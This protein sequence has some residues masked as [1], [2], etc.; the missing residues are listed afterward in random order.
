MRNDDVLELARLIIAA[1]QL[2]IS[3][4]QLSKVETNRSQQFGLKIEPPVPVEIDYRSLRV[5]NGKVEIHPDVYHRGTNNIDKLKEMLAA[6]GIC[7]QD[8]SMEEQL[9]LVRALRDSHSKPQ[10]VEL[11]NGKE[12]PATQEVVANSSI[13]GQ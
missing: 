10:I 5:E 11:T 3:E 7:Y 13:M 4:K 1:R 6:T 9:S 8:L 12:N 2:P